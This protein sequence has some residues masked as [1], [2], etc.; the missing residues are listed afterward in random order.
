MQSTLSTGPWFCISIADA[1]TA[2]VANED[3]NRRAEWWLLG[4]ITGAGQL[5][6]LSDRLLRADESKLRQSLV[7]LHF[8]ECTEGVSGMYFG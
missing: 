7:G 4:L 2:V 6:C 3:V 5:F 8:F 1:Q